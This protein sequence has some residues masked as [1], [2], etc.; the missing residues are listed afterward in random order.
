M[1]REKKTHHRLQ[2][3]SRRSST[4]SV[5]QFV[6]FLGIDVHGPAGAAGSDRPLRGQNTRHFACRGRAEAW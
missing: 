5:D 1:T 4:E 2:L 6:G 3:H